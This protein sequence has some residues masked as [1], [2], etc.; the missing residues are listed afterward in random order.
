MS[1]RREGYAH[2]PRARKLTA[3]GVAHPTI[4]DVYSAPGWMSHC[5]PRARRLTAVGVAHPTMAHAR[6]EY[7]PGFGLARSVRVSRLR[8]LRA[9]RSLLGARLGDLWSVPWQGHET[10]PQRTHATGHLGRV[11]PR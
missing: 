6:R 9:R 2:R 1:H 5:S 10:L 3:V 4:A 11:F 8:R 7:I